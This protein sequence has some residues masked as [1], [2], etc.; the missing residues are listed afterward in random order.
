MAASTRAS[1]AL[2]VL[3]IALLALA[4]HAAPS[5]AVASQG[6][7]HAQRVASFLAANAIDATRLPTGVQAFCPAGCSVV[8]CGRGRYCDDT[9]FMSCDCREGR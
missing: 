1:V 4:A 8:N 7:A 5:V 6:A 3:A 9:G 2:R